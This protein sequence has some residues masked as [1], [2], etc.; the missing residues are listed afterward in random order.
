MVRWLGAFLLLTIPLRWEDRIFDF[1]VSTP[2]GTAH[3]SGG[4]IRLRCAFKNLTPEAQKLRLPGTESD[5]P[6][7][8]RARVWN[9]KFTL[10]TRNPDLPDGW[11]TFGV[12]QST[13]YDVTEDD[14]VLVEPGREAV[15]EVDLAR[16]L[17][18]APQ[19]ERG[20]GPGRYEV[21]LGSEVGVSNELAIEVK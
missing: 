1:S 2:P 10:L 9:E 16:I 8:V 14:Y 4:P 3:V 21:Q 19:L 5:A 17:L 11:W 12:M 15:V 7:F 6:G 13:A 20:L 18:G